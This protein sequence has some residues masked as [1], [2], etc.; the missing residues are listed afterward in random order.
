MQ[1]ARVFVQSMS[2]G[3]PP[4]A[5]PP[6]QCQSMSGV[7]RNG[8]SIGNGCAFFVT[9]DA[10]VACNHCGEDCCAISVHKSPMGVQSEYYLYKSVA[11]GPCHYRDPS[12]PVQPCNQFVP[13]T[14]LIRV[15]FPLLVDEAL[16]SPPPPPPPPPPLPID[17]VI[18]T[19]DASE[20]ATFAILDRWFV[21]MG[22]LFGLFLLGILVLFSVWIGLRF[23]RC[24]DGASSYSSVDKLTIDTQDAQ[25]LHKER[26]RTRRARHV[27]QGATDSSNVGACPLVLINTHE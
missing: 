3:I 6:L 7:N 10:E 20:D 15:L 23:C 22:S 24:K 4:S 27:F 18:T 2:S 17:D 9:E 16:P 13:S 1:W 8:G 25:R 19:D 26:E 21:L 12:R 5:P 11:G 14:P